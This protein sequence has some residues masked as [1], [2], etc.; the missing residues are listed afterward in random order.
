MTQ[1]Q[2]TGRS[3]VAPPFLSVLCGVDG[4]RACHEAARQAAVIAGEGTLR[5]LAVAWAQ[6]YGRNAIALLSR[7]RAE[8]CLAGVERELRELGAAPSV[9]IVDDADAT[10]RLLR[11]AAGHDLL[12]V[13]SHGHSRVGGILTGSTAT[14]VVHRSTVPVLVARRP[15]GGYDVLDRILLAADGSQRSRRAAQIAAGL[16]HIGGSAAIVAPVMHEDAR[17]R[18]LAE[19][20][21]DLRTATGSDPVLFGEDDTATRAIVRAADEFDA[22]LIVMGSRALGGA[23]ALRS[24]SERVAHEAPCSVLVIRG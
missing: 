19:S 20:A 9:D 2:I 6:G 12:V 8:Q 5:L 24:V 3:V 1:T 7:W 4:S 13:A 23:S 21:A 14:A 15:P 18:V 17:R 11:E 22:T 16:A 10:G